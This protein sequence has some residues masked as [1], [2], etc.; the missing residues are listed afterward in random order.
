MA[1]FMYNSVMTRPQK[2]IWFKAKKYG[3]GWYPVTWQG[4]LVTLAFTIGY[5]VLITLF[6]GWLGAATLVGGADYRGAS[7][8]TLEFLGAGA[9]LTWAMIAVCARYGEKPGWHWGDK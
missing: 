8:S 7:L 5:V 6:M 9:L 2:V 3:W 4:A 1:Y